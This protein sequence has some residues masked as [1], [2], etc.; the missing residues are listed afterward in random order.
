MSVSEPVVVAIVTALVGP[1]A[2]V[3]IKAV[4][5]RGARTAAGQPDRHL[6]RASDPATV[7]ELVLE[8]ATQLNESVGRMKDSIGELR[9]DIAVLEGQVEAL[10]GENE[11]LRR[12]NQ[13]LSRQVIEL[14]GKPWRM[15]E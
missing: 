4:M 12:H 10:R 13:L 1:T 3:V 15:P 11:K 8:W 7:S 14:G 9:G 6:R 5:D 2:V